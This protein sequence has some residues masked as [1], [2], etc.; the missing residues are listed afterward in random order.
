M[1]TKAKGHFNKILA[2]DCETS[3]LALGSLDPTYDREYNRHYQSVSWGLIVADANTL[4]S[5]E[6]LYVEIK[7]NGTSEW[8]ARA[9]QVHG[10]SKQYLE[11][12]GVSEEE[13]IQQMGSLILKHF[14]DTPIT[15]LGHN[16][17]S[18]DR[19]FLCDLFQRHG[20]TIKTSNRMVD[21]FSV[22]FCTVGTYN[23]DE[24]FESV[25]LPVRDASKHNALTD[26]EYALE[27]ARRIKKA[28][29]KILE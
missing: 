28:F 27:S 15:L 5:I 3:G 17:A 4:K 14:A 1:T 8:N 24:L 13:A 6:T 11:V 2:V 10:L 19:Y 23:S 7:W 25:G 21:T 16:V 22:G 12:N 29:S 18:F 9:E 26:T 20:I